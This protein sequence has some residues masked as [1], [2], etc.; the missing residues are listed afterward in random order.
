MK[1]FH[2]VIGGIAKCQRRTYNLP[3]VITTQISVV[4]SVKFNKTST[5][6]TTQSF[7]KCYNSLTLTDLYTS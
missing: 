4:Q 7:K 1:N 3:V 5:N 2:F 6:T